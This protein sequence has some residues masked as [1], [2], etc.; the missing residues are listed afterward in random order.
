MPISFE[1][2]FEVRRDHRIPHPPVRMMMV[3]CV[4]KCVKN[5]LGRTW[6]FAEYGGVSGVQ[7]LFHSEGRP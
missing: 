2:V 6:S 7:G 5:L 3:A 4:G 1:I